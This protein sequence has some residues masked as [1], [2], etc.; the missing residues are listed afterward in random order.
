[1]VRQYYDGGG[2]GS[3]RNTVDLSTEY[4]HDPPNQQL[5]FEIDPVD[6][7]W[8]FVP[9]FY[10]E[11]FTGMK[12]KKLDRHGNGCEGESVSIEEVKNREFHVSGKVLHGELPL[13][14]SLANYENPVDLISPLIEDGGMECYIKRVERGN[15]AGWDPMRK[16]RMFEYDMDLVSSGRDEFNRGENGIVTEII[17]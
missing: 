12:A 6:E 13:I 17:G 8:S 1:M 3:G 11:D 10:P 5:G 2:G 15:Q 4:P 16:Q 7:G 9:E 14:H